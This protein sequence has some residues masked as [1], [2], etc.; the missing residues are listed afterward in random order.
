MHSVLG[1]VPARSSRLVRRFHRLAAAA[2]L[3]AGLAPFT[4]A[5][6]QV[7]VMPGYPNAPKISPAERAIARPGVPVIVWGNANQGASSAVGAIYTWTF[8]TNSNLQV[9]HDGSLTGTVTDARYIYEEV[10]FQLLNGSTLET[11]G[12]TLTVDHGVNGIDSD[13]VEFVVVAE[14]DPSSDE[15][16]EKLQVDV[17]ISIEDGLRYLYLKQNANGSWSSYSNYHCAATAFVVWALENQG[18]LP[19]NDPDEDIYADAVA[20]GLDYILTT[21]AIVQSGAGAISAPRALQSLGAVAD[22]VSD[23]NQN[24]QT[25]ILCPDNRAGYSSP[26]ACSA[27]IASLAPDRVVQSGPLA[28]KTYR[29]VVED[30]IDWMGHTQAAGGATTWNGR[31]G[32]TYEPVNT[33]TRSDM[34]I[35]SWLYLAM[36]GAESVFNI[37]V[38]DWIKQECEHALVAHM[39]NQVG[40]FEFGYSN[41]GGC[42]NDPKTPC[43]CGN[44]GHAT[45][46]G[47]LSGLALVE[48]IGPFAT[49]G[50]VIGQQSP[51]L[52]NV[53]AMRNNAITY[54]GAHWGV[55]GNGNNCVG[56]RRNYYAMWTTARA[57]RLTAAA[58][59]LPDGDKVLLS[60]AG[61]GFDWETGEENGSGNVPASG[62][63]E[64]YFHWLV[65]TQNT[66]GS[67]IDRGGWNLSQYSYFVGPVMSTSLAVLVLTPRVFLEPCPSLV[68]IPIV[69]L[70]PAPETELPVGTV[71][72]ISGRAVQP[73]PFEPTAAVLVNEEPVDSLD[74]AGRFFKTVVIEEGPNSFVIDAINKCGQDSSTLVINGVAGPQTPFD[75]LDDVTTLLQI[76]YQNTTFNQAQQSLIVE[77]RV[78][79]TYSKPLFGPVLMVFDNIVSPAVQVMNPDGL[80]PDG[81]PYFAFLGTNASLAPGACSLPKKLIFKNPNQVPIQFAHS[82]MATYNS[83]PKFTTVPVTTATPGVEYRYEAAAADA[84]QTDLTYSIGTGPLAM[85]IDAPT[86][87]VTWTPQMTDVG[88]HFVELVVDDGLGGIGSQ[89]FVLSVDPAPT[90]TVPFFTSAPVTHAAVGASYSYL[91]TAN[92]VDQDA[93]TFTQIAGPAGSTVDP[94]GLVAWPF[95]LPGDHAVTVRVSDPD[96]GYADQAYVLSV[97]STPTNPH[98][99]TLLGNP[100][101][102]A[103]VDELYLYQPVAMDPDPGDTLTFSLPIAPTGMQ[104]DPAGGRVEW[105]PGSSQ[106]GMNP[107]VLSVDDGKGGMASQAWTIDV[108]VEAPNLPP[109]ILSSPNFLALVDEPYAYSVDAIDANGDD[110]TFSLEV[111][112]AGMTIDGESG[113]INWIPTTTG[114]ALVAIRAV[115]TKGAF[116]SQVYELDV[117]PANAPPTIVSTPVTTAILGGKY[118]YKVAAVDTAG[119]N[120]TFG[121]AS[122]PAGMAIQPVT[123]VVSWT[124]P[125]TAGSP[126]S[127]EVRVTDPFGAMDSQAFELTV[128]PDTK[129]PVVEISFGQEPAF[130]NEPLLVCV[131]ANDDVGVVSTTLSVEG[132]PVTLDQAGC[133]TI[134]P[135][136]LGNLAFTATAIDPAGNMKTE[137]DGVI[138]V[139]PNDTNA[140]VLGIVSPTPGETIVG[141]IDIVADIQDDAPAALTWR[142]LVTRMSDEPFTKVIA[143][144]AG[145][146][147]AGTIATF[148]PTILPNDGY[149]VTIEASD[150]LQ[151]S[152]ILIPYSVSGDYKLGNFEVA[153]SDLELPLAG[154]PIVVSRQYTSLDTSKKEFGNGWRLGLAGNVTDTASESPLQPFDTATKVY[155]TRTDGKRVGFTFQPLPGPFPF[156]FLMTP[157]FV[158]DPGVSD[159]LEAVGADLVV[160][161]GGLYFSLFEPFNPSLYEFTTTEKI[162]YLIDEKNGLQKV[163]DVEGNTITVTDQGLFSSIGLAVLY[164]K[165]AEGR[166]T[167]ITEPDDPNDPDPPGS[168]S[169]IYDAIGNLRMVLDQMNAQTEYAYEDPNFPSY[170]TSVMDPLGRPVVKNVFD[171]DGRLIASC[172]SDANPVTLEGCVTF[173][174]D[175]DVG[176]VQTTFDGL[177]NRIDF[178]LNER[179]NVILERR[180]LNGGGSYDVSKT[181]DDQ[182]HLLRVE[183]PTGVI[184]TFTYDADGN[185]TSRT[186]PDG[187][188]WSF[189]YDECGRISTE[190][191]P[192]GNMVTY[193]YDDACRIRFITD[194]FGAQIEL[195]YDAAGEV[196]DF[197]DAEG[198]RWQFTYD[199]YG[200]PTSTIDPR[201]GIEQMQS[202][203]FGELLYHVDRTGRRTDFEWDDRHRPIREIWDTV[204]PRVTTYT[205]DEAGFVASVTDPD[206][207]LAYT[208]WNNGQLKTVEWSGLPGIPPVVVTYGYQDGATLEPGYDLNGRITHVSDSFG[209]V[210]EYGYDQ[211]GRLAL[212]R[213]YGATPRALVNDK[214]LTVEFDVGGAMSAVRRFAG[215][216]RQ[217]PVANS[218]FEYD[219]NGCLNRL[220]AIRH[221]RGV[222]DAVIHDLVYGRDDIGQVTSISDS[223]GLHSYFYDG[224]EQL[225]QVLH[226]TGGAQPNEQYSYD[227]TGNR[228]SSHLSSSYVY[229]FE[230]GRGGN[231]LVQDDQYDYEYDPTG[232]LSRRTDRSTGAYDE[233][234]YDHRSR[235]TEIIRFDASS[236]EVGRTT[237]TYDAYDRRV[238]MEANGA[239]SHYVYDLYNPILEL[240]ERGNVRSRRM[241]GLV[242]DDILADEVT[243]QTRW[244][245]NDEVGTPRD[246]VADDASILAHFVYDSFGR[247]LVET[248][249]STDNSLTFTGREEYEGLDFQYFRART[250]DPNLGRF[251]S[252]DPYGP[253]QYDYAYNNPLSYFDPLGLGPLIEYRPIIAGHLNWIY[254]GCELGK[255]VYIGITKDFSSRA[256]QHALAGRTFKICK[257]GTAGSRADARVIE[258]SLIDS[259][260]GPGGGQL[261]NKINSIA[262][263]RP[264]ANKAA[265]ITKRFNAALTL[266]ALITCLLC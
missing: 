183:A 187:K 59:G 164:E 15:P 138:V 44:H 213:Q 56:N 261:Q 153:F 222:D 180:F 211:V 73:S 214:R 105:T 22:G 160:F 84:Q 155:V 34:S 121:L 64:G 157:R 36:E 244:Y 245:L 205:Y 43:Q 235:L 184:T 129:A 123:G 97:G 141:P 242:I 104:I 41:D 179:G 90:N 32:W 158:P 221:R 13:Y 72:T 220:G 52:D 140:P 145:A 198:N 178:I 168:V 10:T 217:T 40:V 225:L 249:S 200:Q 118:Y 27:I 57:L 177:G 243:G 170:L 262:P 124:P 51:P 68:V 255:V 248:G 232:A 152:S 126:H 174:Y 201:G 165:D 16:L 55:D 17:N 163:T 127:V 83:A 230:Q 239:I 236:V 119:Q 81:T 62:V 247:R 134:T 48:T 139:D 136:S 47:G 54:L 65:R 30:S 241:Y 71:V 114:P 224:L 99:P 266:Y 82:W 132:Q 91:A 209:G 98:A 256:R 117:Q 46:S 103:V 77:G 79:N 6:T 185:M 260:G 166:I 87:V 12:A 251:L 234:R 228:E 125:D 223:E 76:Q 89:S 207:S 265:A 14:T 112:P 192:S 133:A 188:L 33:S 20:R 95:T 63:R 31:G 171:D 29:E 39:T 101:D 253:F 240:D 60:N 150:G 238:R 24:L 231:Q 263:G 9:S 96:G 135:T 94:G 169:Y 130:L 107:V 144:G 4:S 191:D 70:E 102:V 202:S 109:V 149:T 203:I 45:T 151:T 204:P 80:L 66:T 210:T 50:E 108:V 19:T 28:G 85:T 143:E 3:A 78:C 75:N 229:G 69:E 190:T 206:T 189:A 2:A 110:V 128:V 86:G 159:E 93:L 259:H 35:N 233:F 111:G 106:V 195:R 172:D 100:L 219:C 49:P 88:S 21:T 246:L 175:V 182:D 212:V 226:P 250:Y 115:D 252:E 208:Y 23:I 131:F 26:I 42:G 176:G 216:D 142:V 147:A 162:E 11:V 116:G 181:Y 120:L 193:T 37:D 186:D 53:V 67:V 156:T 197:I 154:I 92:D 113:L 254:V 25:V 167:K 1:Q 173:E 5:Q 227:A 74:A 8:G 58:L 38:P 199:A 61:V 18:H 196:S 257:F 122:G 237:N 137:L 148:D 258:Q 194:S 264:L 161:S 218:Y 146:V 7:N 215:A